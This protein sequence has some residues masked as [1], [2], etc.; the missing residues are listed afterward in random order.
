LALPG[1]ITTVQLNRLIGTPDCPIII[2]ICIDD[3]FKEDPRLIPTARR[4]SHI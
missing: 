1:E 3:D 4:H 2:D